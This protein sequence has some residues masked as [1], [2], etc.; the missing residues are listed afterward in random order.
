MVHY[1]E[2]W[3]MWELEVSLLPWQ[4]LICL[5]FIMYCLLIIFTFTKYSNLSKF[6]LPQLSPYWMCL[7]QL[8]SWCMHPHPLLTIHDFAHK[9]FSSSE[10]SPDCLDT[11]LLNLH[12][13]FNWGC[14][15]ACR[16]M[17]CPGRC[18]LSVSVFHAQGNDK[19]DIPYQVGQ[20]RE[21]ACSMAGATKQVANIW[22]IFQMI[23][24]IDVSACH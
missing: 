23:N 20:I 18:W 4:N 22:H 3:R 6:T 11:V 8:S 2:Y 10:K 17:W 21:V 13:Q 9:T 1:C 7:N 19:R 16:H 14:P 15:S 24:L 12:K 5:F